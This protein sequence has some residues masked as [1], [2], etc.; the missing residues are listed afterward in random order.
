M[1]HTGSRG[2]GHQICDDYLE[3][4]QKAVRRYDLRLPDRQL[5]C[6]PVESPEGQRYLGA[7]ACAAN[8]A[9]ANRQVITHWT[10]TACEQ[11]LRKGSEALRL[12]L[13]YDVAHNIAKLET[14]PVNGR[15]RRLC[16]HRKGAT[17]AFGPGLAEVPEAYRHLGQ[18]VIVPGDMG[19][20]SYLLLG[21]EGAMRET[22]GSTCH[23]AG[24]RMSRT[25]A[26]KTKQGKQVYEELRA[27]GIE[28]RSVGIKTLAEEMPEAYKD[29]TE[30]VNTCHGAGISRKVCRLRPLG[31]MKG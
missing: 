31:V 13:V 7:M 8:F 10:R 20:Y 11:V 12:E 27:Q 1:I 21:T 23:G 14:H 4:M 2:F 19:T 16:V 3:E 5:A 30:V 28:V 15:P 9:W 24:R 17:R 29:V 6:A 26:L 18:P 25:Q 22:W